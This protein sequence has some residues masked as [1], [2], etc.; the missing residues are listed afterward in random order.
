MTDDAIAAAAA[1]I[2]EKKTANPS[3]KELRR[4]GIT[5]EARISYLWNGY[6]YSNAGDAIAD[7]KRLT[8]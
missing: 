1:A 6:R 5:T 4:Y 3:D 8:R 7:A 2:P